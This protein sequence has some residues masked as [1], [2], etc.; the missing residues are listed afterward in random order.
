MDYEPQEYPKQIGGTP[1]NPIIVNSH[2]EEEAAKAKDHPPAPK[3]LPAPPVPPV[4]AAAAAKEE[5]K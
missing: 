2:A 5:A 1:E 4:P 3:P